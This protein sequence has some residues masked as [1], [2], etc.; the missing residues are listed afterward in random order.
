MKQTTRIYKHAILLFLVLIGFTPFAEAGGGTGQIKQKIAFI[1]CNI[2]PMDSNYVLQN[3]RILIEDGKIV[4]ISKHSNLNLETYTVID[5]KGKYILP[6]LIDMHTHIFDKSD[7]TNYLSYGVTTVRNMMGMPAHLRWKSNILKGKLIGSNLITAGPTINGNYGKK[8]PITHLR[9]NSKSNIKEI[10]SEQKL[11][12]YDFIKIYN[13]ITEAH[14]DEIMKY[15]KEQNLSVVG[16]PPLSVSRTKLLSSDLETFEHIEQVYNVLQKYEFYDNQV[17]SIANDFVTYKKPIV[18]TLKVFD[19]IYDAVVKKDTNINNIPL[20]QI[21]PLIRYMGKKQLSHYVN[22][23]K[24]LSN[25]IIIKR[26]DLSK[27]LK[28]YNTK[29]VPFLVGTDTGP[30]LTVPGLSLHDELELLKSEGFDNFDIIQAA[31]YLP[32]N[33]LY[34]KKEYGKLLVGS[35]AD[36]IIVN[37]NPIENLSTLR[38]P[39]GVYLNQT[40]YN[41]SDMLQLRKMGENKSSFFRTF[42]LFIGQIVHK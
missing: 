23:S 22:A 33:I 2:L 7:L 10:I 9:L 37:N 14:F 12:G 6:G 26:Q 1:N 34:K 42:I 35:T 15:A 40:Y 38:N 27:M 8:A 20:K 16:H 36:F 17:D 24:G 39:K 11:K 31:T 19:N 18:I 4:E 3:Y 25:H 21:N 29:K 13:G 5:L 41:E 32:K 28:I 30:C